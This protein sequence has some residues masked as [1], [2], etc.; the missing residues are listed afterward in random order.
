MKRESKIKDL[1]RRLNADQIEWD[2]SL[3]SC[4]IGLHWSIKTFE[5]FKALKKILKSSEIDVAIAEILEN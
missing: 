1:Q 2:R 4:S 5:D 3:E